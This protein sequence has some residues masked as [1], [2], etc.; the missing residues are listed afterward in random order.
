[1]ANGKPR[2]FISA[3][4]GEFE[5]ARNSVAADLRARDCAVTIQSDFKQGPDSVTLLNSLYDY[6]RDCQ[7]V[8]CLVGKRAG[9]YPPKAAAERFTDMLLPGMVEASYTQWEY[10]FARHFNRRLYIYL[11]GDDWTPDTAGDPDE[12]QRLFAQ[13]LMN[14]GVH[15]TPFST[16]DQLGRAILKEE[17]AA[18]PTVA[19]QPAPKPIVLPYPSIGPLFKGRTWFVQQLRESLL[20]RARLPSRALRCTG[21][22]ALARRASRSNTRGSTETRMAPCCLWLRIHLSP[23]VATLLR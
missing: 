15:R 2:V 1:M 13:Y 17:F 12:R 9:A 20:A 8:V 7:A 21:W 3:V 6:I 10:L 11:A 19:P 4:S 22:G 18:T 16:I 23:C 5:T 14:Q